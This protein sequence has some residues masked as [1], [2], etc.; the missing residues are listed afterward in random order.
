MPAVQCE[1]TKAEPGASG[2]GM[3][4]GRELDALVAEKV[5]GLS[6]DRPQAEKYGMYYTDTLSQVEVKCYSTDI[7]AA[8]EVVETMQARGITLSLE[9]RNYPSGPNSTWDAVFTGIMGKIR[10]QGEFSHFRSEAPSA[11][12]AICLA[13]LKSVS[14]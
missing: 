3:N 6:Y 12:E 13:A 10:D 1:L 14:L 8:W 9:K 5:M 2:L 7:A 11:P 4:S